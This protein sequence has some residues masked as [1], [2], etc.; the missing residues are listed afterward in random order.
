METKKQF[1]W[2]TIFDYEKEQDYLREMHKY[3]WEYL[4][5]FFGY[6]YFRKPVD[7]NGMEDEIFCDEESRFQ[8]MQRVIKGRMLPLLIIFFAVLLPQL[9]MSLSNGY[10]YAVDALIGFVFGLYLTIFAIC[11]VKYVKYKSRRR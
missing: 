11:L 9:V 1:K 2:F 7:E 10:G 6:S 3:G 8:M 5:D 4:Q